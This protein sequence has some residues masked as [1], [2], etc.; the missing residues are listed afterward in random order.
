MIARC[1]SV[2]RT[3]TT[4]PRRAGLWKK[5]SSLVVL[6]IAACAS[7]SQAPQGGGPLSPSSGQV[8][9]LDPASGAAFTQIGSDPIAWRA[10]FRGDGP[11]GIKIEIR[12]LMVG[13]K[14]KVQL[15][16]LAGP[17]VFDRR[18]GEGTLSFAGQSTALS[19]V[20]PTPVPARTALLIENNAATPLVVR[21]Y[22]LEGR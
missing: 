15:D 17:A 8:T 18:S 11:S 9:H 6:G 4:P 10:V 14:A 1:V 20:R 3:G 2:R 12:D 5:A 22:L 16:P 7:S 19:S 21:V 13:P